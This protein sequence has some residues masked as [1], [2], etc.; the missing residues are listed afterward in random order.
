MFGPIVHVVRYR[1]G[2]LDEVVDAI[3]AMGYG[4]TLGMHSRIDTV[5][6][7]SQRV[8]VSGISTSTAI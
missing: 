8:R 6:N 7:A 5:P 2:D 4:L 3:N 1:A